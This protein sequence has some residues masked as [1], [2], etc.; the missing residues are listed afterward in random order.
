[1][2]T[3]VHL[4]D[5]H[6][7]RVDQRLIAPITEAIK[8]LAPDLLVVSGDL[9]Q[10]ARPEQFAQA[11]R[12][13]DS[14]PAPQVVVPGNH[15]IPLYNVYNRFVHPLRNYRQNISL[16]V[17]PTFF[18]DQIAV[19]GVNTA[20]SLTFKNGRINEQQVQRIREHFSTLP[21]EVLKIVVTHHP[22]D[23]ADGVDDDNRLGR[24]HMA[25]HELAALGVDL[26]LSGHLHATHAAST[27]GN[28][29]IEGFA[30]LVVQAGTATSTRGRGETNSFNVLRVRSRRIRVERHGWVESTGTFQRVHSEDFERCE[31]RWSAVEKPGGGKA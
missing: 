20:R 21:E 3:I 13:L 6:F 26:L 2:R 31:Q 7:G 19:M 10:R 27:A 22:F 16:D 12:F 8:R 9:T 18:D 5:L 24:A 15:D 23:L 1:M 30:A 28:Y 29:P 11:Q 14:L 25:M 4:S 17:E